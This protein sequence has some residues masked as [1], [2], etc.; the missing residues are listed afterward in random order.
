LILPIKVCADKEPAI[1]REN[2]QEKKFLN[3]GPA[4]VIGIRYTVSGIGYNI[5]II[6]K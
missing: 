6:L 3:I 5:E 2:K 4:L 1:R